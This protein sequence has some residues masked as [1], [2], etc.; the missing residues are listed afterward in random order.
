ME[1]NSSLSQQGIATQIQAE[2]ILDAISVACCQ[3]D[4]NC[5][6]TYLNRRAEVLFSVSKA[7]VIGENI[8]QLFPEL[9]TTYCFT[10]VNNALSKKVSS[11]HTFVSVATKGWVSLETTS[12]DDGAI[13][14]FKEIRDVRPPENELLEV[15]RRFEVAQVV[16]KMGY[17]E[18]FLDGDLY[19]SDELYRIYGLIPQS[20]ILTV[21]KLISFAHP[22]DQEDYRQQLANGIK[23]ETPFEITNRIIRKDG[24]TRVIMRRIEPL[25]DEHAK[26][27]RLYGTI[28]DITDSYQARKELKESKDLLQTVFDA[29]LI[30]MSLLK[31]LKDGHGQ[32]CDFEIQLVN[33]ELVKETGRTDLIGKLYSQ[34][35]PGIIETGLFDLMLKVM[36]NGAPQHIEYFYPHDGFNKWYSCVFAKIPNGLVASNMDITPRKHAE[37]ENLKSLAILQEAEEVGKSG[38]WTMDLNTGAFLWSNGMYQLFGLPRGVAVKPEL[39]QQFASIAH[40]STADRIVQHIYNQANFEEVVEIT[41]NNAR[42]ILKIKATVIKNDNG[43][44]AQLIGVDRDIT[45]QIKLQEAEV[46]QQKRKAEIIS[47]QNKKIFQATI[48]SQEAE[49]K[50]LANSLH[51]GLGQLLYAVKISLSKIEIDHATANA[52]EL[53]LTKQYSN[54]LLSE[55]IS[56]CRRISQELTPTIL[57]DFGLKVAV[58]DISKQFK[59][60]LKLT[61]EFSGAVVRLNKYI[62]F[63]VYRTIQELINHIVKHADATE[64]YVRVEVAPI[65]IT[66]TVKN[67]GAGFGRIDTIEGIDLKMIRSKVKLLKGKFNLLAENGKYQTVQIEIPN[68]AG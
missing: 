57:E 61:C 23:G 55:A 47:T 58:N 6:L 28:Q 56:E 38:S 31:A 14:C 63:T 12:L 46:E 64:A 34:E 22:E 45:E 11:I 51:D 44:P 1:S 7:A 52:D 24:Q 40:I 16:G 39:Y 36:E 59:K 54:N 13:V 42:K 62:E 20:E 66:L 29:S 35:Y 8:W 17:F 60:S 33:Q 5:N 67:N 41:V 27:N 68:E 30:G 37:L 25:K 15:Q 26:V 2:R 9:V 48:N 32:I 21:E 4:H 53:L 10:A 3:L 18:R 50:R 65:K 49:R 43:F 19:C